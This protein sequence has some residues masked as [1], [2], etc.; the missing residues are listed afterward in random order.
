MRSVTRCEEYRE[1]PLAKVNDF[2]ICG[3]MH[4]LLRYGQYGAETLLEVIAEDGLGGADQFGR[5]DHVLGAAGVEHHFGIREL[6]CQVSGAAAVVNVNVSGYDVGDIVQ[7]EPHASR[8]LQEFGSRG[9]GTWFD[10]DG[11]VVRQIVGHLAEREG[12]ILR[13]I[14]QVGAVRYFSDSH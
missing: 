3:D 14:E 1:V 10:Q 6:L 2:A 12:H 7:I 5:V 11:D 13:A 4:L 8:H 9:G